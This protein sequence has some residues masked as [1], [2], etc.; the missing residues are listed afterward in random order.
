MLIYT[1]GDIIALIGLMFVV[2]VFIIAAICC[3]FGDLYRSW[4]RGDWRYKSKP[5]SWR[6]E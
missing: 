5:N 3:W 2:A 6:H 1:I 4:R